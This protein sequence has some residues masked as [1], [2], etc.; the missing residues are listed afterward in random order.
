MAQTDGPPC[1]AIRPPCIFATRPLPFPTLF[2]AFSG[3]APEFHQAR[4]V[5]VQ[6]QS[7]FQQ[8][9][10]QLLQ[11]QFCLFPVLESQHG[12][13]RVP[14]DDHLTPRHLLPPRIG[15]NIEH[16]MQ[17]EIG[18]NRRYNRPGHGHRR[19]GGLIP[20]QVDRASAPTGQA[21]SGSGGRSAYL[22]S[23]ARRT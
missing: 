17:V 19:T 22:R 12:V 16:A 4:L 11:K 18:K 15:P 8:P 9:L 5:W 10:P 7:E 1:Q 23:D 6:L 20:G 3:I 2:P 13:V 21:I 14:H